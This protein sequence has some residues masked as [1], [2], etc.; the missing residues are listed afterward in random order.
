MGFLQVSKRRYFSNIAVTNWR[1][2]L[3]GKKGTELRCTWSCGTDSP[4]C[5][6]QYTLTQGLISL[7]FRYRHGY[8]CVA[9][10]G[11][12]DIYYDL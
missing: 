9:S 12:Y 6:Q 5:H 2:R 8:L 3:G 1:F 10:W 4:T 7:L 11:Y